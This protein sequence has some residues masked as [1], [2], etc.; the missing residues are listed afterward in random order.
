MVSIHSKGST[1]DL[2]VSEAFAVNGVERIFVYDSGWKF[3]D[4]S[5]GS[6]ELGGWKVTSILNKGAWVNA[7]DNVSITLD[8]PSS[9]V[10]A[11]S[12]QLGWNLVGLGQGITDIT[13]MVNALDGY[14]KPQRIFAYVDG[15]WQLYDFVTEQGNLTELDSDKGV[16]IYATEP[17]FATINGTASTVI[18]LFGDFEA[19]IYTSGTASETETEQLT[20]IIPG[21]DSVTVTVPKA[22]DYNLQITDSFGNNYAAVRASEGSFD[23]SDLSI[24]TSEPV[25]FVYGIPSGVGAPTLLQDVEVFLINGDGTEQSMGTILDPVEG[26]RLSL[27]NVSIFGQKLELRREGF[28]TT[29]VVVS[30]DPAPVIYSIMNGEAPEQS[31]LL[32]NEEITD[33]DV[34]ARVLNAAGPVTMPTLGRN[35]FGSVIFH[36]AGRE[37]PNVSINVNVTPYTTLDAVND[38]TGLEA[39]VAADFVADNPTIASSVETLQALATNDEGAGGWAWKVIGGSR[40]KV[41]DSTT[42]AELTLEEATANGLLGGY[43]TIDPYQ[44]QLIS[45]TMN[46]YLSLLAEFGTTNVDAP[47]RTEIDVYARRPGGW[48]RISRGVKFIDPQ[49]GAGTTPAVAPGSAVHTS[50]LE[51]LSEALYGYN[52]Q[53]SRAV[54]GQLPLDRWV[55][56]SMEDGSLMVKDGSG[57]LHDYAFV[58]KQITP[59]L[60]DITVKVVNAESGNPLPY[61]LVTLAGGVHQLTDINGEV[62]FANVSLPFSDPTIQIDA[63]RTDHYRNTISLLVGDISSNDTYTIELNEVPRTATIRGYVEEGDDNTPVNEALVR[64]VAPAALANLDH[65]EENKQFITYQD[66]QA[67]YRWMLKV[68][69][70]DNQ[71]TLDGAVVADSGGAARILITDVDENGAPLWVTV[72][73]ALGAEDG[74]RLT[75]DEIVRKLTYLDEGQDAAADYYLVGNYDLKLEIDYD[76][77]Q[78]GTR[79]YQ[80]VSGDGQLKVAVNPEYLSFTTIS[81]SSCATDSVARLFYPVSETLEGG[82]G[83]IALRDCMFDIR[84]SQEKGFFYVYNRTVSGSTPNPESVSPSVYW[85]L[86]IRWTDPDF[87]N[88]NYETRR[89]IPDGNGGYQWVDDSDNPSNSMTIALT[90]PNVKTPILNWNHLVA[91][92][93]DPELMKALLEP[94]PIG[95]DANPADTGPR[96]IDDIGSEGVEVKV[97]AVIYAE[98]SYTDTNGNTIVAGDLNGDGDTD[99]SRVPFVFEASGNLRVPFTQ[100]PSALLM[101]QDAAVIPGEGVPERTTRSN[102]GGYYQFSELR[103]DYG[104]VS[105]EEMTTSYLR[106]NADKAG[107]RYVTLE[108]VPKFQRDI[109]TTDELEDIVDVNIDMDRIPTR[110]VTVTVTAGSNP[111]IGATVELN[112]T[113][114]TTDETGSI[115]ISAIPVGV[116]DLV[117]TPVAGSNDYGLYADSLTVMRE[118]DTAVNETI[119]ELVYSAAPQQVTIALPSV[120]WDSQVVPLIEASVGSVQEGG[121]VVVEGSI[122][123]YKDV[124]GTLVPVPYGDADGAGTAES[125]VRDAASIVL[126]GQV[127]PLALNPDSTFRTTI[128][129]REGT[130]SIRVQARNGA[131]LG[132][133]Q[134]AI[135]SYFPSF[136]SITGVVYYDHDNDSQ[137]TGDGEVTLAAGATV[138]LS[139]LAGNRRTVVTDSA[140]E[141]NIPSLTAGQWYGL[142]ATYNAGENNFIT[143]EQLEIVAPAGTRQDLG[144]IYLY[145]TTEAAVGAPIVHIDNYSMDQESGLISFDGRAGNY[146]AIRPGNEAPNGLQFILNG[147]I[148]DIPVSRNDTRQAR[149]LYEV[150]DETGN[151]LWFFDVDYQL[152]HYDNELQVQA[153][154]MNG[155][156][157]LSQPLYITN[158]AASVGDLGITLNATG[159]Y[160][161]TV[162]LSLYDYSGRP[163]FERQV[164]LEGSTTTVDVSDLIYGPYTYQVT[165]TNFLTATGSFEMDQPADSEVIELAQAGLDADWAQL[166]THITPVSGQT[167]ARIDGELVIDIPANLRLPND[168]SLTL[169]YLRSS[170][171]GVDNLPISTLPQ[172]MGSP[173]TGDAATVATTLSD[174]TVLVPTLTPVADNYLRYRVRFTDYVELADGDNTFTEATIGG[175]YNEQVVDFTDITVQPAVPPQSGA[176]TITLQWTHG[177]DMDLHSRYYPAWPATTNS[178]SYHVYYANRRALGTQVQDWDCICSGSEQNSRFAP[179]HH[180]WAT[181]N[182][183]GGE[184]VVADGMYLVSIDD[185]SRIDGQGVSVSVEG[186]GL[187]TAT[188]NGGGTVDAGRL[189]F[190]PFNFTNGEA[191]DP[192]PALLIQ[193]VDNQIVRAEV[194]TAGDA[195]PEEVRT[196]LGNSGLFRSID[197]PKAQ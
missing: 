143:T 190:G 77:D 79:D 7:S 162:M 101:V 83:S 110:D 169:E 88:G 191:H 31:R 165:S 118:V 186:P 67:N 28:V 121:V 11:N 61:T 96:Y 134:T 59:M 46:E 171:R 105:V 139:D 109:A 73:E 76:I 115:T 167:L 130:N 116:Y 34:T 9:N 137:I 183:G 195:F 82:E 128:D 151:R 185:Y 26:F 150:T 18:P 29:E 8:G 3:Y 80:E 106:V 54:K 25:L 90:N 84:G 166:F 93:S 132:E 27:D 122:T 114:Y 125:R 55:M 192:Q 123:E 5:S 70:D 24:A 51:S 78:N 154:N 66:P 111:A 41:M 184:R 37:N 6:G 153:T 148:I 87:S 104:A 158:E 196:T 19:T 40:V 16:W 168:L 4:F 180:T 15:G 126:N 65:D 97:R 147:D 181:H 30:N 177:H 12:L 60:R 144:N 75:H 155:E 108:P 81:G 52:A 140:G 63:L 141:F 22:N 119:T 48:E 174:N 1:D 95:P 92:L 193:V 89:L 107:F 102:R 64:L 164:V 57:G 85:E 43:A 182:A 188:T 133:T 10:N 197:L 62:T 86:D 45:G 142:N 91:K 113:A 98:E 44:S 69:V 194:M 17:L 56:T 71:E 2:L 156:S 136:G 20:I 39:A 68:H 172:T 127:R 129:L 103:M 157:A 159:A 58:L 189:T 100:Q 135:R 23:V 74:H 32:T 42:E 72:K 21:Q 35:Q 13:S 178:A 163:V 50:P 161:E 146:D 170:G 53:E 173:V 187:A 149:A 175:N 33:N 38:L 117:V 131:G 99:D 152:T 36:Q 94:A 138:I 47:Y 176:M 49:L 160:G 112:G 145:T 179:E 124:D 14:V 120:A